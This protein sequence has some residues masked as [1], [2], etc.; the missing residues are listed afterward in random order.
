VSLTDD[1]DEFVVDVH[2]GSQDQK[3][4][5][6]GLEPF[7]FGSSHVDWWCFV[8]RWFRSIV[9]DAT[10]AGKVQSIVLFLIHGFGSEEWKVQIEHTRKNK[11]KIVVLDYK[12][13]PNELL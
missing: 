13:G 3:P 2:I 11:K 5:L 7:L 1:F 12:Q 4:T 9:K 6:D 8:L 10:Q